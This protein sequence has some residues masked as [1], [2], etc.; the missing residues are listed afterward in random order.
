MIYKKKY[1]EL[2]DKISLSNKEMC[3]LIEENE[4]LKQEILVKDKEIQVYIQAI[5]NATLTIQKPEILKET[6]AIK[7]ERKLKGG[8]KQC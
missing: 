4:K 8:E 2:Y 7:K 6:K 1:D 3:N 5:N